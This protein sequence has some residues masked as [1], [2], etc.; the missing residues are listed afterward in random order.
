M[1]SFF[2]GSTFSLPSRRLAAGSSDVAE[3]A[4]RLP[5]GWA[6]MTGRLLGCVASY[7]G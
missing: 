6:M 5:R 4:A 2:L 7:R 1:I 3:S